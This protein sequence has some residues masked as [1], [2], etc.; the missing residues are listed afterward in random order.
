ME[1]TIW[2]HLEDLRSTVIRCLFTIFAG[3][4]FSLFFHQEIIRFLSS[5]L[6]QSGLKI[7]LVLLTPL[8]GIVTSLKIAFISGFMISM[9]FWSY[10]LLQFF[11]PALSPNESR[12]AIP[13]LVLSS[14]F[15]VFG[16]LCAFFF[17][18][19]LANAYLYSFN[20]DLGRN[21]W[22]LPEYLNY[23][24]ALLLAHFMA[25][26]IF[27]VLLFLV[28]FQWI[29]IE[30]LVSKRRHVIVGA[31]ILGAILTP[32]DVPSQIVMGSILIA[33]YELAILYGKFRKKIVRKLANQ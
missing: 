17:T 15:L 26:E 6:T 20:Q 13:F 24:I 23:S 14:V 31:F 25:F 32:P 16:F 30:F 11:L 21:L 3:I 2:E 27:A 33:I 22:S 7:E 8:D 4:V 5:P 9:P 1:S 28:H 12:W 19:P 29:S 10:H 18:I